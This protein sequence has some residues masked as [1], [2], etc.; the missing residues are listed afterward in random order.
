MKKYY[1]WKIGRWFGG[2]KSGKGAMK[3]GINLR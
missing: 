2:N 1:S 3:F